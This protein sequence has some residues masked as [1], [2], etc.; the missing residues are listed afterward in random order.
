MFRSS[1]INDGVIMAHLTPMDI[2]HRTFLKT[3]KGYSR[4]EVDSFIDQTASAFEDTI[5]EKEILAAKNAELKASLDRYEQIEK[6]MQDML[7]HAQS[8][9]ESTK[10][11]AEKDAVIII[12]EAELRA[13]SIKKE[14]ENE[15][16][17][18]RKSIMVLREQK[19]TFLIKFR[20]LIKSQIEMLQLLETGEMSALK[21]LKPEESQAK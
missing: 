17:E 15:L 7:L 3:F 2:R 20:T 10:Q 8:T 16:E 11:Q 13:E 14:S 6:T 9:A 12:K 4:E 21:R 5:K 1:I 19:K 18:L